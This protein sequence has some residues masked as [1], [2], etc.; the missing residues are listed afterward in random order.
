MA[1]FKPFR[2]TRTTLPTELHDGYAYFCTDDGSFHIDYKDTDGSLKRR[3]INA[4]DAE[5]LTGVTLEEIKASISWN[6]LLDK[7]SELENLTQ[8]AIYKGEG[9]GAILFNS[10]DSTASG[11]YSNAEGLYTTVTGKYG[12]AEGYSTN[13]SGRAAHAEGD[14]ADASGDCAH[15]EGSL[16]HAIGDHSHA[17]GCDT[18]AYGENAHAAGY[19]TYAFGDNQ[20]VYGKHSKDAYGEYTE[21]YVY[22]NVNDLGYASDSYSYDSTT[23]VFTLGNDA[24]QKNINTV[25][26]Q[27]WIC[28]NKTGREMYYVTSDFPNVT[29]YISEGG[30][31]AHIVG[32]GT[33]RDSRSNSHTLDWKGNAWFAGEIRVGGTCYDNAYPLAEDL[34]LI[35]PED[36]DT[37]CGGTIT[38]ATLN[39]E[40]IF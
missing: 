40:V 11:D 19:G 34:F 12:H 8:I 5:T 18:T 7:P 37:I 9:E 13:V 32:N 39:N 27:Y 29:K 20:V 33:S 26:G 15:A 17:E 3:Q 10:E 4:Q 36:I 38:A 22:P 14:C 28:P 23:G 6:D 2:G 16:T 25:N 24:I 35:A 21:E 1:L 31:Y 30:R